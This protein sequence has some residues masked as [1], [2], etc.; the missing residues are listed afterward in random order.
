MA[1]NREMDNLTRGLEGAIDVLNA[2]GRLAV[3]SYHSLEDRLVKEKLRTES[4]DCVCPPGLPQCVC[5]HKASL[6]LVNRKV[7]RPSI[8]EVEAN[9][10][11]RSARMR[12]AERI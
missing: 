4:S 3:M 6:R 1:V 9:P 7:I 11:A 12:V 2:G 5:G 10:R 8:D